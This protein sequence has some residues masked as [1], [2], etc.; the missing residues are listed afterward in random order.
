M[1]YKTYKHKIMELGKAFKIDDVGS[2]IEVETPFINHNGDS[3]TFCIE[4]TDDEIS[5]SDDGQTINTLSLNGIDLDESK[6]LSVV[7]KKIRTQYRIDY[8]DDLDELT[9][10]FNTSNDNFTEQVTT[11]IQAL[12]SIDTLYYLQ[13]R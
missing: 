11:Y 7:F 13:R 8:N 1:N 6:T 4:C 10:T 5:L 2:M 9:F 3:I 12:L